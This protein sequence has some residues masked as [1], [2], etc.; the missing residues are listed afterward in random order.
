MKKNYDQ[1]QNQKK[2]ENKLPDTLKTAQLKF[3][4]DIPHFPKII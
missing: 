2:N 1:N 4:Q 3:F